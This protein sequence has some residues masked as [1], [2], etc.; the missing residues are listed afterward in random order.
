MP[1]DLNVNIIIFVLLHKRLRAVSLSSANQAFK[2]DVAPTSPPVR[3]RIE[4]R[5]RR[6]SRRR[7]RRRIR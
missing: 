7:R 6:L 1:S 4:Q 5:P 2:H 3:D